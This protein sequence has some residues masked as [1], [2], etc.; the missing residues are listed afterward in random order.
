MASRADKYKLYLESVQE[1]DH[2]VSFMNRVYRSAYGS[3]PEILR[4][5]FCGTFAVCCSWVKSKSSR[6]AIGVDI[7][8]EPLTWGRE[9]ILS[10]IGPKA[11]ARVQLL[12]EDVRSVQGPK[13]DVLAAQNFSF[14]IFKTRQDLG[15]YFRA[16]YQNLKRKGVFVLDIMGGPET[17][18]E[19]HEDVHKHKGFKYVWDQH[20]FDPITHHCTYFIH[21]RF[22]D[23]STLNRAFQYDWRLWTLPEIRELLIEAGFER[24]DVYWEDTDKETGEGTDVYRRREHAESDPAWIAYV[25]GVK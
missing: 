8:P 2:E 11:Q 20:R 21:F 1:P 16:A 22:K 17:F 7:D 12:Q 4:E 9:K 3:R 6:Q 5:D 25:V 10:T 23:G 18:E 14:C 24:A 13:A 19:D 15:T